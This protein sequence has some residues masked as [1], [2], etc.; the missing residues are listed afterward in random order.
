MDGQIIAVHLLVFIQMRQNAQKD[1]RSR[2]CIPI[3]VL[4]VLQSELRQGLA[5]VLRDQIVEIAVVCIEGC[6]GD[7]GSRLRPE[8]ERRSGSFS[9][10]C[11][12]EYH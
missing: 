10:L 4:K 9:L 12:N 11:G 6:A 7:P 2:L 1:L 8:N 3:V 5:L